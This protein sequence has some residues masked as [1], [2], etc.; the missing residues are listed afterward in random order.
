MSQY[1]NIKSADVTFSHL[2]VF[3]LAAR[4]RGAMELAQYCAKAELPEFFFWSRDRESALPLG[5]LKERYN[6]GIRFSNIL[7]PGAMCSYCLLYTSR[8]V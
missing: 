1:V 6:L 7:P 3:R 2:D 4:P 8:C 5:L